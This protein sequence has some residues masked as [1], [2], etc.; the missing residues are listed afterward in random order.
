MISGQPLGAERGS[1]LQPAS[2]D[3]GTSVPWLQGSEFCQVELGS[4]LF[5]RTGRKECNLVDASISALWDPEQKYPATQ[6]LDL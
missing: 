1:G 4:Q 2:E 6:N 3:M 5:P